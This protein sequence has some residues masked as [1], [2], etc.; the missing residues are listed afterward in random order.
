[1]TGPHREGHRTDPAASL[2]ALRYGH[3]V[4]WAVDQNRLPWQ[5]TQRGVAAPATDQ[6]V[7]AL[8]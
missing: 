4:L 2:L 1:M 7:S 3:G 6:S 5:E 8:L